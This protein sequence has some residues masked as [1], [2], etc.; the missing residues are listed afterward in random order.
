M[1]IQFSL[2]LLKLQFFFNFIIY[3]KILDLKVK[4]NP[5]V[6]DIVRIKFEEDYLRSKIV[7]QLDIDSYKVFLIDVGKTVTVDSHSIFELPDEL[8]KVSTSLM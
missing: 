4:L 1:N 6:Q 3:V 5:K 2:R 8:K 7:E